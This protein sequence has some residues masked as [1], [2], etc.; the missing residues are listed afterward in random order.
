MYSIPQFTSLYKRSAAQH[1]C[2]TQEEHMTLTAPYARR[3]PPHWRPPCSSHAGRLLV[4][5]QLERIVERQELQR[6]QP[7]QHHRDQA[8]RIARSIHRQGQRQVLHLRVASRL[9]EKRRPR[10]LD[11]LQKQPEHR[12]RED[13]RRHL[14]QLVEAV[15][16]PGTSRATCGPL[17]SSGMQ[18]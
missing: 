4:E 17:T 10:Q 15:R 11:Q 5:R 18:R 12:L 3:S 8:R 16:Q 1:H 9:A 13:L 2:H 7:D 6:L 14:D